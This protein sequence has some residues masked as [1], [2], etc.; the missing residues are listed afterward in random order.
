MRVIIAVLLLI[1]FF[2]DTSGAK[3]T[4]LHELGIKGINLAHDMQFEEADKIFDEM[5]RM[6][7][8]NAFGYLLKIA[9]FRLMGEIKGIENEQSGVFKDL[10]L[11]TIHAAETML[12][13]NE[14][15]VDAI[16]F[17]GCAYGNLGV[18]Y[19]G[20]GSWLRAYWNGRKGKNYLLETVEKN[21]DY[22]DAY[23]GLG[24]YHYYADVLPE[25]IK[26]L[27]FLLGIEGDRE[28]GI[29]EVS[30]ASLKGTYSK[31]SAKYF[32]AK[33]VYFREENYEAAFPLYKEL[34]SDYPNNHFIRLH[35]A[36]CCRNLKK[37]DQAVKVIEKSLQSKTLDEYE[38]LQSLFYYHLG[39]TWLDIKKYESAIHA[40]KKACEISRFNKDK[41]INVYTASLFSL[42]EISEM[43]G[44]TDKARKYYLQIK[45]SD[46]K[47]LYEAARSK[48]N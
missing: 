41:K 18:Y 3:S 34:L 2:V 14:D 1:V 19:T 33:S 37:Y 20:T 15:D 42:G 27:S 24:M 23:L 10:T 26:V 8:D 40:Y 36:I 32:L 16:F 9:S 35:Y 45:K 6:E 29:K 4:S 12:E 13:K 7:P 38:Y 21:P 5:I 25:I 39:K 43:M 30:I 44:D 22:Y 11:K 46:D 17:L 28:K 31:G 47:A 48:V